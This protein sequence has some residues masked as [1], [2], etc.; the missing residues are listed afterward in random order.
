[1]PRGVGHPDGG[2]DRRSRAEGGGENPGRD[3]PGAAGVLDLDA[4]PEMGISLRVIQR[5]G[6]R[7]AAMPGYAAAGPAAAVQAARAPEDATARSVRLPVP[8]SR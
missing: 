2:T 4:G 1:M 8:A 5:A 3:D 7:Q 6:S